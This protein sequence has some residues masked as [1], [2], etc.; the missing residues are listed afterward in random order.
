MCS[1]ERAAI[2]RFLRPS[3]AGNTQRLDFR[4]LRCAPPDAATCPGSFGAASGRVRCHTPGDFIRVD[5]CPSVAYQLLVKR[6]AAGSNRLVAGRG[7]VG[8][9]RATQAFALLPA[10]TL[11]GAGLG[12]C[13]KGT[14]QDG[15]A[16]WVGHVSAGRGWGF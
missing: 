2:G 15:G 12:D 6:L 3:G 9:G 16:M 8:S 14:R 10:S 11:G 1:I 13:V 7:R 4:G 5:P